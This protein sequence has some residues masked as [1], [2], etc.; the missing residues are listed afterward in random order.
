MLPDTLADGMISAG[1]LGLARTLVPQEP[2]S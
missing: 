2:K 1:G